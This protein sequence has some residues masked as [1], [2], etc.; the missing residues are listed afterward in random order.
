MRIAPRNTRATLI[1]LLALAAAAALA[2]WARAAP[3]EEDPAWITDARGCQCANPFP[4]TGESIAWSGDCANGFAQGQGVLQ[5]YLDGQAD[6]RFE[7]TLE[8][9]WAEGR[10]SL[11][12]GDGS[13]YDG[14]WK[15]SMQH[16]NG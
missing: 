8:M 1:C 3:A 11:V 16:G 13:K 6:D 12:R 14:E 9:G 15:Q 4:R 7:G 5:W 2:G 10:G